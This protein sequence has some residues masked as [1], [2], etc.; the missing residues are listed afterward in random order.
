MH[1]KNCNAGVNISEAK[2]VYVAASIFSPILGW[3]EA[4]PR[5]FGHFNTVL[6]M[7]H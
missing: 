3:A 2:L 1:R 4:M 7:V 5:I 6:K